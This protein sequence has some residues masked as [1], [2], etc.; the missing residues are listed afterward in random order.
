MPSRCGFTL[1]TTGDIH[2]QR[3]TERPY[4]APSTSPPTAVYRRHPAA[5]MMN[6][7]RL[8]EDDERSGRMEPMDGGLFDLEDPVSNGPEPAPA[9]MTSIQRQ[10][11]RGLFE[12]LGVA[13]AR[14]QF[15]VVAELTGVQITSVGQLEADKASLLIHMLNGRASRSHRVNT[16]NA[17]ADREED[18]WIDRL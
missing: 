14:S 16:G 18:T 8:G 7:G 11:I 12:H 2:P 17:W 4:Y 10:T 13:D 6:S 15:D 5:S 9:P 3:H 1:R